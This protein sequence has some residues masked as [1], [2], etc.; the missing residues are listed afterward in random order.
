MQGRQQ[1][2]S[3][4]LDWAALLRWSFR[5]FRCWNQ[6]I[7]ISWTVF[8][9]NQS[10]AIDRC[11]P[12][13]A[14]CRMEPCGRKNPPRPSRKLVNRAEQVEKTVTPNFE[15]LVA[16]SVTRGSCFTILCLLVSSARH[17]EGFLN[18]WNAKRSDER[19]CTGVSSHKRGVTHSWN[20]QTMAQIKLSAP[21]C[22]C[23]ASWGATLIAFLNDISPQ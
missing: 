18:S 23:R 21:Q 19:G 22:L 20:A 9:Y 8:F 5:K 15:L 13:I 17:L 4:H 2:K 1:K 16:S 6:D 3:W 11:G 14:A 12:K 7:K 10:R